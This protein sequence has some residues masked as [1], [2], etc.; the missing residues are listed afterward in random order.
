MN[1]YIQAKQGEF[2]KAID[3]FKKEIAHLRTGRANP[4]ILD[5]VLAEAY[6]TKTLLNGL[7][8]ITVSDARSLAV[9]PWD[10]NIIKDIEKAVAAA[11]LGLRIVNEGDKLRLSVPIMTEENRRNLVKK[12]NEKME[13]ARIALR[14]ARDGTKEDIER[15]EK[16]KE[17]NEDDKFR[18]IKEL[19]EEVRKKNEELEGIRKKKEE[20]IMTI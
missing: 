20:E 7:A 16:N 12:L 14:Q 19:D 15:G 9:A 3:F 8:S 6:G 5:G 13:E 2:A 1:K 10:K 11:N 17:I 4:A 18:F